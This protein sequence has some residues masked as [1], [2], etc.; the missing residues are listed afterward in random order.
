MLQPRQD[1]LSARQRR[2]NRNLEGGPTQPC[3]R[4]SSLITFSPFIPSRQ[5]S[6]HSLQRGSQER[7]ANRDRLL[8]TD[9]VSP[10]TDREN[11]DLELKPSATVC[12]T[13]AELSLD[14]DN[15]VFHQRSDVNDI[16]HY[17]CIVGI[18]Q[19][20]LYCEETWG[21]AHY[22]RPIESFSQDQGE[23]S[24][25]ENS[26]VYTAIVAFHNRPHRQL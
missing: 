1:M 16:G 2:S 4:S 7:S 26:N 11:I 8:S 23:H 18:R 9:R 15:R 19:P 6:T 25:D 5:S 13:G 20:K 22:C 12:H 21:N 24:L 17:Q 3:S 10:R 14:R